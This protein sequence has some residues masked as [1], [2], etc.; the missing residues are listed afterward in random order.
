MARISVT[1]YWSLV[2]FYVLV[3]T[4][5]ALA[6]PA[7]RLARATAAPI[8]TQHCNNEK[9]ATMLKEI[10]VQLGQIQTDINMLKGNKS[11]RVNSF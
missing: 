8:G 2:I 10:K 11:K 6:K 4:P 1:F 5:Q 7:N 3:K 9:I